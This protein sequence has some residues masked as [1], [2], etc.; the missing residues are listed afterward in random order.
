MISKLIISI[1]TNLY[2]IWIARYQVIHMK[3]ADGL[4]VEERVD[5][6]NDLK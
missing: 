3:F 6:M 4:E 2:E 1:V 5:L